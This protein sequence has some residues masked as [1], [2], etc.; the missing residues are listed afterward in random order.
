VLS[1]AEIE[2]ARVLRNRGFRVA[3][4]AA[5]MS[6]GERRL[7]Q[8]LQGD[9]VGEEELAEVRQ[10]AAEL[11]ARRDP[12]QMLIDELFQGCEGMF[13]FDPDAD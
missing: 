9:P 7:Y 8:L 6:V 1:P 10:A 3:A 2:D 4:I 5:A 12:R 11:A 13:D